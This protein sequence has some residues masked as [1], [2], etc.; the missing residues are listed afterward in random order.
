M[1]LSAAFDFVALDRMEQSEDAIAIATGILYLTSL[2][3]ITDYRL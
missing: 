1:L 2:L 3:E